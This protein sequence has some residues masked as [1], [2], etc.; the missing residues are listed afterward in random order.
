M[1]SA[2]KCELLREKFE[3]FWSLYPQPQ[4]QP[5]AW[6]AFLRLDPSDDLFEQMLLS[7]QAQITHHHESKARGHWVPHWKHPTNWL[8]QH[9]WNDELIVYKTRETT[10]AIHQRRPAKKS[11]IEILWESC[12]DS[13]DAH[14]HTETAESASNL[15]HF[16]R[17]E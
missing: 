1:C 6:D 4:N 10:H 9:S 8:M 17:Q 2:A 11:S 13:P 15:I 7:L 14:V 16:P 5:K 12:K 3:K